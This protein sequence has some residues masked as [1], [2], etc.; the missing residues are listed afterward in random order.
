MENI[1]SLRNIPWLMEEPVDLREYFENYHTLLDKTTNT[2]HQR[3]GNENAVLDFL[4]LPEQKPGP[5]GIATNVNNQKLLEE[6]SVDLLSVADELTPQEPVTKHSVQS[7]RIVSWFAGTFQDGVIPA[8]AEEKL[9]TLKAQAHELHLRETVPDYLRLRHRL[10]KYASTVRMVTDDENS[11]E[12][13]TIT[14]ENCK[15]LRDIVINVRIQRPYHKKTHMKKA[16][17]RFP[18]HSQ[19][20]LVLGSQKLTE[21]RDA[22]N[23]INDLGVNQDLS[24]DPEFHHLSYMRNNSTKFPS[25]F[26][27]ING[28]FYDDLRQE[29][30]KRYSESIINWAKKH[31]EI[32]EM[33]AESMS[34]T[35]FLDLK[36]RLGYPYIFLHQ[37][38]CEHIIVFTDV[39]LHH[40][41]D[42]QDPQRFPLL[43]GQA[44]KLSVK[45][46]ICSL[47][48]ANWIVLDEPRLP[49]A[50]SHV[51]H[52]C[53]KM[54]CY[55]H[56][57][58][59]IN[60]F[61]VYPFFDE[62]LS[63]QKKP[64]TT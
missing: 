33:R 21:L 36:M 26:F 19:E 32:G 25:G 42:V 61:K 35:T 23:C 2:E 5:G 60:D 6:C 51:C 10:L 63:Q 3:V 58:E 13:T 62:F 11:P 44:S 40:Q 18:S 29:G 24:L 56:K 8:R 39:R 53:L 30:S 1:V 41:N 22:I 16:C 47:N 49:I 27:Y 54:F 7:G 12:P 20:L 31:P 50:V 43:R 9:K 64:H 38:N 34:E 15:R 14:K 46:I 59:K 52:R 45:C 55:N 17:N 4:N 37:G 28:V 57:G 48:L